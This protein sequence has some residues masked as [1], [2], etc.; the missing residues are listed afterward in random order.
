MEGF[1]SKWTSYTSTQGGAIFPPAAEGQSDT[2]GVATYYRIGNKKGVLNLFVYFPANIDTW[3]LSYEQLLNK[4]SVKQYEEY[5]ITETN[6]TLA[7]A[8]LLD[9]TGT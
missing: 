9:R 5:S 7:N 2:N 1:T 4:F 6:K 3:S 8:K